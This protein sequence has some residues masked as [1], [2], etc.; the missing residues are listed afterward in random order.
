MVSIVVQG[1]ALWEL[2][3]PA[4]AHKPLPFPVRQYAH[5]AKTIMNVGPVNERSQKRNVTIAI[6]ML[7]DCY[8]RQGGDVSTRVC[9]SVCLSVNSIT[10]N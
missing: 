7:C 10:Y 5:H 3:F 4:I 9:L 8:L 6:V 1:G 2:H